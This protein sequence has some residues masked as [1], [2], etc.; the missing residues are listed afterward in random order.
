[1]EVLSFIEIRAG[2]IRPVGFESL[3]VGRR[4][5]DETGG[6][7]TALAMGFDL[8]QHTES[9]EQYGP[10][11]I[12]LIENDI[13]ENYTP[14]GYREAVIAGVKESAAELVIMGRTAMG[15]DLAPIIAARLDSTLLPDVTEISF[16]DNRLQAVR[17]VY[18]GRCLMT[19]AAQGNTVVSLRPKAF[20][21][22]ETGSKQPV[23]KNIEIDL[24]GKIKSKF[25]EMVA[26]KGEK[27]DVT[28]ADV[29]VSGGRGLK[30]PGNFHIVEELAAVL[31]AAV[32]ASR[33]VVDLGWRPHSEQVGQTGKVV[34]PT[35]Y[36]AVGISG[37]IQ[38]LAGM[39]TSKVIVAINK[40]RDAPI[41]KIADYGIVGDAFKVI[42]ELTRAIKEVI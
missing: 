3:T 12:L 15:R 38:H 28:E 9:I 6:K 21:P 18:G 8:S 17:P 10:D 1:M 13:L 42:P 11:F 24:S 32:G 27:V 20:P 23:C 2:K 31:K 19:I 39:R 5:A 16:V 14:E 40:D 35:L 22:A 34:S 25:V 26:E 36:I 33:A 29:I 41:F 4:I 7:L 37:A 30:E